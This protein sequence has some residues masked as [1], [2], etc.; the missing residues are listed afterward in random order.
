MRR[1]ASMTLAVVLAGVTRVALVYVAAR[2]ILMRLGGEDVT[3]VAGRIQDGLAD[4]KVGEV[5]ISPGAIIGALLVFAGVWFL[6]KTVRRWL[7]RM[8][9]SVAPAKSSVVMRSSAIR[10]SSSATRVRLARIIRVPR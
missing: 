8:K 6:T 2:L 9:S 3:S 7:E 10:L 1:L 5:T 4:L